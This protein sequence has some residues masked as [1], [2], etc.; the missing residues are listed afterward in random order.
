MDL[1]AIVSMQSLELKTG[2][3]INRCPYITTPHEDLPF[4]QEEFAFPETKK[5]CL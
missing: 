2:C 5:I 4:H 3:A 1:L